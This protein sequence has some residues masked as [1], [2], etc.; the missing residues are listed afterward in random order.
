M[1]KIN[2]DTKSIPPP[3]RRTPPPTPASPR[4]LHNLTRTPRRVVQTLLISALIAF[5]IL[6]H[7]GYRLASGKLWPLSSTESD[8][9]NYEKPAVKISLEA[10]MMSKCPDARD[11]LRDLVV[12]AMEK[13]ADKVDFRMSYIGQFVLSLS[14]PSLVSLLTTLPLWIGLPMTN[15]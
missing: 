14:N 11:C 9:V 3:Y 8:K 13:I 2:L 4:L 15:L 12:P 1:E 5:F 10:H 6:S 7:G